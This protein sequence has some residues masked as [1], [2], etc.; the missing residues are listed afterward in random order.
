M[1]VKPSW[2]V[3]KLTE[4]VGRRRRR[5]KTSSLPASRVARSWRVR[6]RASPRVPHRVAEPVVPL[7]STAP[8]T[9]RGGT[10]R[11]RRPTVRRSASARTAPGPPPPPRGTARRGPPRGR[12]A[13]AWWPGRSGS[14][15]RA[16][17]R[18]SSAGPPP[19]GPGG[20]ALRRSTVWRQPVVSSYEPS[21]RCRYHPASSQPRQQS[22]GPVWSYSPVWL[23]TTSTITSSPASWS[24]RTIVLHSRDLLAAVAGRVARVRREPGDGV[25]APQVAQAA[26]PEGAA[27]HEVRHRQQLDRRHP[28]VEEVVDHRGVGQAEVGATQCSGGTSGWR[29]VIDRTLAS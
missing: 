13:A 8:G 10:R 6:R 3:T 23:K 24:V 4:A 22:V 1:S 21:G 2:L 27:V 12:P 29:A 15:P 28:E 19:P 18:P 20:P 14:R 16:A 5:P 11:A 7:R 26:R 25:V 9:R 17:R